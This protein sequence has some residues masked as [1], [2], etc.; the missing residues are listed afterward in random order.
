MDVKIDAHIAT[1]T[2]VAARSEHAFQSIPTLRIRSSRSR[3]DSSEHTDSP[4]IRN[5]NGCKVIFPPFYLTGVYFPSICEHH[6]TEARMETQALH[7]ATRQMN[8]TAREDRAAQLADL[9]HEH[10]GTILAPSA[11]THMHEVHLLGVYANGES[12]EHAA[13]NWLDVASRLIPYL[14]IDVAA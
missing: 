4:G 1:T 14:L 11:A 13:V 8:A 2:K 6:I 7:Q 9:V 3:F 12:A 10:G 5:S